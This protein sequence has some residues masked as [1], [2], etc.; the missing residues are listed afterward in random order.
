MNGSK[1][2]KYFPNL[3]GLRFVGAMAILILHIESIK[4]LKGI[5][6][7]R[8]VMHFHPLGNLAVCMFFVLSGFLITYLLLKERENTDTINLKGFYLK[9]ILKIWPLYFF[10][11]LFGIL[12]M[13]WLS[14]LPIGEKAHL[15]LLPILLYCLFLPSRMF[16]YGTGAAWSVRVEEAFYLFWPLLL[17]RYKNYLMV[18]AWVVLIVVFARNATGYMERFFPSHWMRV[19]SN[20]V[21]DYSFSCMAIGGLGAYLFI[22]DKREVLSVIYRKDAQWAVYIG[23]ALLLA[24][25]VQIPF[26]NNEFYSVLFAFIIVNL[27]TNPNSVIRLDYKWMSY[28]GKVSYGIYMYNPFMRVFSLHLTM[29]MFGNNVTGIL[30]NL[31]LYTATII[32]SIIISVISFELF[33]KRFL[34]L[35]KRFA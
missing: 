22:K 26:I 9:R 12:V 24:F 16:Q 20:E 23:T 21:R 32:T 31:V 25:L 30:P 1:D 6:P 4:I 2:I 17:R 3:D 8:W 28:L 10:I 11:L 13:P 27:A 7:M 19:I 14:D 29:W 15:A 34:N 35:K 33:E 18:F 5:T